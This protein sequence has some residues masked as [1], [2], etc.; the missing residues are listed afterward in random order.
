MSNSKISLASICLLFFMLWAPLGQYGFLVENWMKLG[1]YA[2][3]FL[4]FM[5]FAFGTQETKSILS[6]V[7]LMSVLMLIAY[8]V[9]QYEEH[10][11]DL[12]GN[13]YAFY[14]YINE[15][16]LAVFNAQNTSVMPLSPESIFVINTS[17]VW[18]V[19]VIAIWRSPKHLFPA[20]A[21]AGITLVNA[22]SHIM[23]GIVK[24]A[25]NPG[26]LTAIV[27]FVP[28]AIAFYRSVLVTTPTASLQ[29]KV[30]VVRAVLAHI[31]MAGGLLAANWFKLFPEYVYFAM[32]ILWSVA[33][34]FL[35]N[36]S[37][38]TIQPTE[39]AS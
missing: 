39:L 4:L 21:M 13:Q 26:L 29:V 32:L 14:G 12:F 25:Y 31:I 36:S 10:W 23:A 5:F 9:H 37:A 2:A 27:I 8:I 16:I 1:I 15:L 30:S 24:Q 22:G 6:D 28:L 11:I 7:K 18:L 19:G 33:P 35:F 3:P 34:A 17:L 38:Q 20:L